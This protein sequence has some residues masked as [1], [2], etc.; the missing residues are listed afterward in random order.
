M[1]LR[2]AYF[3][4]IG[5]NYQ[6]LK[7]KLT[8][9]AT[10]AALK[11]KIADL[12]AQV[13]K[14]TK[15][16]M[17]AA[18][19]KVRKIMSDFGITVEQLV[20]GATSGRAAAKKRAGA[21]PAKASG[22]AKYRDPAT[23]AT[24]TGRGRAPAWIVNSNNRDEFLIVSPAASEAAGNA[25]PARKK[26]TKRAAAGKR[27]NAAAVAKKA[28]RKVATSAKRA[29]KAVQPKASAKKAP[30]KKA[31]SKK[32]GAKKVAAKKVAAKVPRKRAARKDAAA[33]AEA[34]ETSAGASA[35]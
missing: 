17:G 6:L 3:G 10:L 13:E 24:W 18:I 7:L 1:R 25:S 27:A 26:A 35:T 32:V 9:M 11:K 5:L 21:K 30:A 4:A 8:K 14:V 12:E 23:G 19:A 29:A 22:P 16:E 28:G 20:E 31:A 15:A 34:A 33:P 2:D